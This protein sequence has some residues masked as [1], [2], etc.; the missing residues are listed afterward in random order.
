MDL[1]VIAGTETVDDRGIG[2]QPHPLAKPGHEDSGDARALGRQASLLF[3]DGGED[4]CLIGVV[5][6]QIGSARLPCR[7]QRVLHGVVRESEN[8]CVRGLFGKAI[9]VRKEAPLGG[10][11]TMADGSH[12]LGITLTEQ[13]MR[14]LG[15]VI[16]RV[17]QVGERGA[18]DD[19]ERVQQHASL[20]E[21]RENLRGTGACGN[22]VATDLDA[23]PLAR[24]TQIKLHGRRV[25][26][27]ALAPE[28]G[29]DAPHTR[30][31]LYLDA[32]RG[33]RRPGGDGLLAQ[34]GITNPRCA[35]E[36]QHQSDQGDAHRPSPSPRHRR[37]SRATA[38]G[39]PAI[40]G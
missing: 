39:G 13:G 37:G 20:V 8:L 7:R 27:H 24:N 31:L 23:Q 6:G 15:I 34:P 36:Q 16:K 18:F 14:H 17:A 5:V 30:A 40:V 29:E 12:D 22:L 9:R 38:S 1:A 28:V 2:L 11:V 4:E 10:L 3:H 35:G 21:H 25:P 33:L 19:R 32:H 26:H